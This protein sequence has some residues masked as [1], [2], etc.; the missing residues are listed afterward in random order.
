MQSLD[1][2][3]VVRREHSTA[4]TGTVSE[5]SSFSF[6]LFVDHLDVLRNVSSA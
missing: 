6:L 1:E 2:T 5:T 4:E 3:A